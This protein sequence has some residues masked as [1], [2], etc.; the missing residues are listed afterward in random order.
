MKSLRRAMESLNVRQ[1]QQLSRVCGSPQVQH[2]LVATGPVRVLVSSADKAI[3]KVM[4]QYHKTV[5]T[6]NIND[7]INALLYLLSNVENNV[8][9]VEFFFA[10]RK[11]LALALFAFRTRIQSRSQ[12]RTTT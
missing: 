4:H 10:F 2:S 8:L 7:G 12:S 11:I 6:I 1:M 3:L 9:L 5:N